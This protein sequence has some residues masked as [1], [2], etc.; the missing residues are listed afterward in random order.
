[1]GKAIIQFWF[2]LRYLHITIYQK[3][4]SAYVSINLSLGY[5]VWIMLNAEA[6]FY[7]II[8]DY[9]SIYR[10]REAS[11]VFLKKFKLSAAYIILN[12]REPTIAS[13]RILVTCLYHNFTSCGHEFN[14]HL[15][16]SRQSTIAEPYIRWNVWCK[17][18][19]VPLI[20]LKFYDECAQSLKR[21]FFHDIISDLT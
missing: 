1:M 12:Y 13:F 5:I 18:Q 3:K 7:C 21:A 20:E 14:P 11:T 16:S 8:L 9:A 17:S 6:F 19:I 10:E 4:R 2:Y 15:E